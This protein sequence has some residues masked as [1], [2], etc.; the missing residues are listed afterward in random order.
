MTDWISLPLLA[1]LPTAALFGGMLFFAGVFA[2]LVFMKLPFE[3][4]SGFI[5]KVFP[6]YYAAGTAVAGVAGL[7]ALGADWRDGAVL[8][9]VAAGFL[10][11]RQGIMPA[12]NRARDAELAGDTA[13]GQRFAALHR[14]S[15]VL[16]AVQLLAVLV[17]LVRLALMA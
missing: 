12:V 7:L 4:A 5:R 9:F 14:A 10:F 17:V 16:N 11:A 1:L 6:A 3:V 13:A 2:P 8:L 15:V